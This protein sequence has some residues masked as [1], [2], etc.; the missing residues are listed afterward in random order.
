MTLK[1][2]CQRVVETFGLQH[3][4]MLRALRVYIRDHTI[5]ELVKEIKEIRE[6]PYLKTLWEAGLSQALQDAVLGQLKKVM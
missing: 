6:A 3:T 1:K 5:E 2:H 4:I